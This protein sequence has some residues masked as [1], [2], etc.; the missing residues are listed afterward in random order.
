MAEL[1]SRSPRPS[2][3]ADWAY[4][5]IKDA[6]LHLDVPMGSQL[7]IEALAETMQI[8]RTPIREA[9]LSL[10]KDGLVR[11]IPR[12]GFFVTE[13]T[14]RDLEELFELRALLESYATKRATP[15]LTDHELR[16][17][18]ELLEQSRVAVDAGNLTDFLH[19]EIA[20]H[21][22]ITDHA[23]NKRLRTVMD[24]LKDLTYRERILSLQSD[25]N[26]QASCAEHDRIVRALR[27]RDPEL[28]GTCMWE[29]IW[30][31]RDR[32]LQY[33]DSLRETAPP[34]D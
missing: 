11:A 21:E 25:E 29:H 6:I 22:F 24:S 27:Q 31:V 30:G 12:V 18:E 10:E 1:E 13:I 17:V 7:N 14:R 2:A 16:H 4:D 3:L 26:V 5:T 28:A 8:S 32:M 33:V 23:Q 34:T 19:Y 9:L 20:L 15:L